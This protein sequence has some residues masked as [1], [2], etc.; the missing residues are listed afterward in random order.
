METPRNG[1]EP[2]NRWVVSTLEREAL[3]ENFLRDRRRDATTRLR[4][5]N[6]H[7]EREL[8]ILVRRETDEPHVVVFHLFPALL[9][10][11]LCGAGLAG[12]FDALD[13]GVLSG[14]ALLV[15][16]LPHPLPH[17]LD[18]GGTQPHLVQLRTDLRLH[19]AD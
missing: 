8:G 18:I 5:L 14:A 12:D 9:P 16:H 15:D 6:H 19:P 2:R 1:I 11:K 4:A 13:A 10:P 7:A 3:G 17:D